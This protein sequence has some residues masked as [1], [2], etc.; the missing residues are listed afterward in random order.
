[1]AIQ[2]RQL[3]FEDFSSDTEKLSAILKRCEVSSQKHKLCYEYYRARKF[4]LLAPAITACLA[5]GILGFTVTTE[6]IKRHMKLGEVQVEDILTLVVG[7]LGFFVGMTMLFMN[8]WDFGSREAMHLSA[9]V[10]LENLGDRVRFWKMDRKVGSGKYGKDDD[11]SNAGAA[12]AAKNK[13]GARNAKKI[14]E[15]ERKAL[16]VVEEPKS[17]K[18]ALVVASGKALKKAET[19]IQKKTVQAKKTEDKRSDVSRFSGFN[20]AYH[21]IN[22]SCKSEIPSKLSRPF[23]LFETRLEC[24]SLGHLGVIWDT[25]MRRNQIMRLAAVEIYNE[26]TGHW[27][28]PFG[29]P[30]IEKVID[31]SMKRVARLIS[32]DYR[33]PIKLYCCGFTIFRCCCRK[34]NPRANLLN[35][36]ADGLEDRERDAMYSRGVAD[37]IDT[38][39]NILEDDAYEAE[40][41]LQYLEDGTTTYADDYTQDYS[42]GTT[43]YTRDSRGYSRGDSYSRGDYSSRNSRGYTRGG[44]GSSMDYSRDSSR[45]DRGQTVYTE[46]GDSYARGI[47]AGAAYDSSRQSVGSR[48]GGG[49]YSLDDTLTQSEQGWD[50]ASASQYGY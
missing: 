32:K 13:V 2:D 38:G 16:G 40:Q 43:R 46:E 31:K 34:R 10:E 18:V 12:A 35:S 45:N 33:A 44:G 22:R 42:R 17:Q 47:A 36:I 23:D 1:M 29:T 24:M 20:G 28:W 50:D 6:A 48:S 25:R 30:D 9:L 3:D 39:K 4:A 49:R 27:S 8:Q 14:N 26:L 5:I 41:K 15:S 11:E 37:Y 7:F 19:E 21:Q